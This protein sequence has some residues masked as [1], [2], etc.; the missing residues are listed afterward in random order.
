MGMRIGIALSWLVLAVV[1]TVSARAQEL[2]PPPQLVI[3][4]PAEKPVALES[5][6]IATDIRGSLAVTS[7]EMRFFNPNSRQL[8]GELQFPLLDGQHVIGMA[9]DVDGRL[10]DGVPVERARG[11][12]VF[13]EV[14]RARID[15]A[16]LQVTQGNNYKLRVYPILPGKYKTVVIRYAESLT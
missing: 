14:A 10:R 8:E 7:V 12:A 2:P 11:Q 15:P 4:S 1:T 3:A 5:V 13:E 16:L 9:M 6:R